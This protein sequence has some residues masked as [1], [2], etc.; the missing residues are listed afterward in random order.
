MPQIITKCG[1]PVLVDEADYAELSKHSWQISKSCGIRYARK[2]KSPNM[3]YMHRFITKPKQ[4]LVVDHID[5]N[6]LNNQRSNLRICTTEEN[7]WNAR[8]KTTTSSSK[9]KGVSWHKVRS[10]WQSQI[11]SKGKSKHLGY[12]DNELDAAKAYQEEKKTRHIL[13]K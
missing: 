6:G 12:F 2:G 1:T 7:L 3:V 11:M 10:K 8:K 9:F 4:G 5:G 13:D